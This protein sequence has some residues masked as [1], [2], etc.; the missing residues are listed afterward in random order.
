MILRNRVR[1]KSKNN[2][3]CI[4]MDIRI[5]SSEPGTRIGVNRDTR[6]GVDLAIP[7]TSGPAKSSLP[8]KF[9][10]FPMPAKTTAPPARHHQQ[11]AFKAPI[12]EVQQTLL[13]FANPRRTKDQSEDEF[14]DI[15]EEGS[16]DDSV[17]EHPSSEYSVADPPDDHVDPDS[18]PPS[19]GFITLEDEKSDLIWKLSRV[20]AKGMPSLRT[21]SMA[22]DIREMRAELARVHAEIDMEASINFQRSILIGMTTGVE[23]LNTRYDPFDLQLN[24]WSDSV[25]HGIGS[26]DRV[27]ERLHEKYKNKVAVAPEIE[28]L[29]MI[30]SSALMFHVTAS[31]T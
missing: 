18:I 16:E 15:P 22:S 7:M 2:F 3:S 19:S 17:S 9:P 21:F 20:K 4:P 29:L 28:L 13:D 11:T 14:P 24:G 10:K 23:L 5:D 8:A 31:I 6:G 1:L 12:A 26:Y 30:G 27:F 25:R